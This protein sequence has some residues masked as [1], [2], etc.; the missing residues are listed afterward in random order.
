[1]EMKRTRRSPN[2]FEIGMDAWALA[3]ES[4]MVI[5]QRMGAMAIGGGRPA[6]GHRAHALSDHPV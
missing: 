6:K 4:N 3:A 5:A 1:M 2:W